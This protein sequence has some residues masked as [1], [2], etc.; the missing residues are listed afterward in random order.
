M[1][2]QARLGLF[3]GTFDPIHNGHIHLILALLE[4]NLVDEIVVIPTGN[5][6]MKNQ[7]PSASAKDRHAMVEIA[8]AEL[9]SEMQSRISISDSEILRQGPTYTID[10]V[11]EVKASHPDKKLFLIL[12]DEAFA[13]IDKWHRSSELMALIEPLVIAREGEG[14]DIAALDLSSTQIREELLSHQDVSGEI[15]A[16]VLT[17]IKERNLYAS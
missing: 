5:P 2:E 6:W 15:P 13:T 11:N 1:S 4:R 17:Y 8:L 9:P 14:L 10:T 7:P 16:N 12:G 3:G